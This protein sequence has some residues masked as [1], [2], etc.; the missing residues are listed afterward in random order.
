MK[1]YRNILCATD[2]SDHCRAAAERAAEL[3]RLYGAELTLLHVVEH[4]PVDRSNTDIAP[5][6]ID[7]ARYHREKA[8]ASLADLAG[9]VKCDRVRQEVR[10]CMQ[11]ARNEILRFVEEH[12]TDLVVIAS[13]GRHGVTSILGSTTYG[14]THKSPCDVLAVRAGA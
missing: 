4:F 3:A 7:P 8:L 10:F 6:D 13:H 1:R 5:E 14:V 12:D 9:L 2:F 11:S